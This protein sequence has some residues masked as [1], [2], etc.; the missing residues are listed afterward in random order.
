MAPK[1]E[2]AQ[3][4]NALLEWLSSQNPRPGDASVAMAQVVG[5]MMGQL[6]HNVN[7]LD[8][9]LNRVCAVI[10]STAYQVYEANHE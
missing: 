9:G 1:A 8:D 5:A 3:L 4:R 2:H 6:A 7:D 10:R